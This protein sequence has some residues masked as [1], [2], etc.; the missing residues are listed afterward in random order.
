MYLW[1][2]YGMN[3]ITTAQTKNP[4]QFPEYTLRVGD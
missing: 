2:V 1:K 4:L 3:K